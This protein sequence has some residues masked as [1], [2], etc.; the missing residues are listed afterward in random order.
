MS[1]QIEKVTFD[2]ASQMLR[3]KIRMAF[4]DAIPD[5]QW[6]EMIRKELT[7]FFENKRGGNDTFR[8]ACEQH[9]SKAAAEHVKAF[10]ESNPEAIRVE[11]EK[12][13]KDN[14]MAVFQKI[15]NVG[16]SRFIDFGLSQL[17]YS[18]QSWM[19]NRY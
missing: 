9:L 3:E 16:A 12:W 4:V 19:S 7:E 17:Q 13:I 8:A 1:D 6:D 15:V 2:N 10:I 14:S 18:V 5:E 11:V